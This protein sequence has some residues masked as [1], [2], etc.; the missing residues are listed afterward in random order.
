MRK[1]ARERA[2]FTRRALLIGGGQ[3]AVFGGIAARLYNLQITQHS[4]YALLAEHNSISERLVAPERGL[5]TDRFGAIVAGNQQHWRALFL[6]AMA[7]EPQLVL[8]NFFKLVSIPPEEQTRIAQDVQ[9]RPRYIPVLLK[10]YLDWPDMAAIEINTPNLPGVMVEV[11]ASR[12]YPLGPGLA[13]AVGYVARPSQSEA[14]ADTVLALPGMRVGRT[15]VEDYQ[16]ESLRGVPGFVQTETNVHGEVVRE[17]AHDPG[18]PG[19]TVTLAIDAGLQQLAV[20]GLGDNAGAVVMLDATNGEVLAM[21][22]APSFDPS[23]FDKGV[24]ADVWDGWMK[25][26]K[27][28]LQN[29]AT[30][31]LFAPGSTFKPTVALAAM[32]AGVLDEHTILTCPGFFK[33][34][35]HV[36]WCDNHT[37]HGSITVT[38]ALQVSCDVFFYQVALRVG[39]DKIAD[40]ATTMG[41][42]VDLQADMPN[43]ATG[44]VPTLDWAKSRGIHWVQGSTV[45][46]GIGQGYTQ[47]TPLAL[48][49]MIARIATGTA[50]GPHIA[51]RVGGVLQDGSDPNDWPDLGVDDRHLAIIRQGLFEVVNTPNGTGY[52]ARLTLPNVQMAGKTGTAQT[53]DNTA[54]EKQQGFNDMTMA[55]EQRPNALFVAYAP[56]DNPRYAVAVVIEHGN[57]GAQSAAPIAHDLMTYAL[58]NDPA[59]RDAPLT[60]PA[61]SGT[62]ALP[63]SSGA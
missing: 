60:G 44:L 36:F 57:Y 35:D 27:H 23:L 58:T 34:G 15:G 49:T 61:Q 54:A 29:K 22:S 18:T 50:V 52:G 42:G 1:I 28:P 7:P 55:W 9:S 59:G 62:Q 51:R 45:V 20:Q 13:H 41:L 8:E 56:F 46:Q 4:K 2:A 48:A 32:K 6:Q 19:Q 40:M 43:V 47:L 53:H 63:V 39:I 30:S 14:R 21:A 33:L 37:A 11:G 25:D 12:V 16:D 5:I 38:T 3:A 31:G 17:V 26:P 10:D 24:P